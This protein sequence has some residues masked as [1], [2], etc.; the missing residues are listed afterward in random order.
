[1]FFF[2]K[3]FGCQIAQASGPLLIEIYTRG[4][5]LLASKPYA[6]EYLVK[7]CGEIR[8]EVPAEPV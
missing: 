1:M 8:A 4:E 6:L 5:S 7:V 2:C 3:D